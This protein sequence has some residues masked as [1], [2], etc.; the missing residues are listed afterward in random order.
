MFSPLPSPGPPSLPALPIA[1][2]N[3]STDGIAQ[4]SAS[5]RSQLRR[6]VCNVGA[7]TNDESMRF[8]SAIKTLESFEPPSH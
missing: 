8:G 4:M 7:H 2:C 6:R 5:K 3:L 1:A